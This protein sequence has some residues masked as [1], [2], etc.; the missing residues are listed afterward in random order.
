MRQKLKVWCKDKSL[1]SH[2]E[3]NF[4]DMIGALVGA[5]MKIGGGIFGG[6]KAS[7]AMK[8]VK[9][10]LERQRNDNEAW[11]A[12]RYN[13]DATQR[14]D[15]QRILAKTQEAIRQRN[16]DAEARAVMTGGTD[17]SLA[18]TKE[19]NS[20]AMAEAASQIAANGDRRKDQIEQAYRQRDAEL[21]QK[22]N[23]IELGRAGSISQAVQGVSQA[24]AGIAGMS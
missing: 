13:E 7:Q 22:L 12:R 6:I 11:Y 10:S 15:A 14:A 18:R 19:A 9:N 8:S 23:E 21:Q 20:Q 16:A 2:V 24:G 17:A 3:F 5:A 4:C 1:L